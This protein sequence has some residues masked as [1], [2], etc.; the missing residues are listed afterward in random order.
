MT[1]T[2]F[3]KT[4]L[5]GCS[6]KFEGYELELS[7]EE[8]LYFLDVTTQRDLTIPHKKKQLKLDRQL[9]VVLGHDILILM[10]T[11]PV[12]VLVIYEL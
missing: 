12:L 9:A 5:W 2:L 8:W 4:F 10:Q 3:V 1:T 11:S 6:H 7:S